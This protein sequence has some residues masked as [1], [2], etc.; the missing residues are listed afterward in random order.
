MMTRDEFTQE[1]EVLIRARY[2][3]ILINTLEE[4]RAV[5]ILKAMARKL[6][7]RL[8]LW[9]CTRGLITENDTAVDPETVDLMTAIARVEQLANDPSLFVWLDL[10]STLNSSPVY[11]RRFKELSQEIRERMPSNSIIVGPLIDIPAEL[12]KEVTII[13]MPYPGLDEVKAIISQFARQYSDRTDL[14]I[15]CSEP[16]LDALGRAAIGLSKTEIENCLAKSLV[17]HK[18]ISMEDID[19][20]LEEKK[21]NI[22]KAGILEYVETENLETSDIGGLDNMK[23]WLEIRKQ[24]YTPEAEQFGI[25]WPKGVLLVGVPGCG[26]SLSAKCVAA[27]W[28]MPLLRLDLG[29]VFGMYVGTSEANIRM[30]LSMC[31]AVSPSILWID[32]IEKAL[33]GQASSNQTDGGTTSR[34]FGTILTWMQEKKSPV[35]V[36]ATANNIASLPPELLRKGRFDEI[37]FVDLPN[38]QERAEIFRIHIKRIGRNPDQYDIA[39]MV[40][41]S[42]EQTFGDGV[43]LTGSEIEACVNQA[44]LEAFFVKN[45]E[46]HPDSDVTSADIERAIQH[47]VPLSRVRKED[48][49]YMRSWAAENAVRAS[50]SP[51]QVQPSATAALGTTG[52][53]EVTGGRNIDF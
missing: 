49:G 18:R 24:A 19:F 31:E 39:K 30:A 32:E 6:N 11:I 4:E 9:S 46:N 16:T 29:R 35:F 23:K 51:E 13:D 14:T 15:D 27:S 10:Q 25:G 43:R 26:K 47:S 44:L 5:D 45:S 21:Q 33:S 7:K 17:K 42:G 41:L 38:E 2:G 1:L 48:I 3:I 37:F 40:Q 8:M 53:G 22:R 34:V 20:I 36:F 28:K 50:L 12:Q 52:S